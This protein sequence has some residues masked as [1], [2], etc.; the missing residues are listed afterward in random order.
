MKKILN[1]SLLFL[2]TLSFIHA[3]DNTEEEEYEQLTASIPLF[4]K[5]NIPA[6]KERVSSPSTL[7]WEPSH[8]VRGLNILGLVPSGT[9]GV[10]WM[11]ING[12]KEYTTFYEGNWGYR[13]FSFLNLAFSYQ[14]QRMDIKNYTAISYK[15]GRQRF[16]D[17]G[18]LTLHSLMLK[19]YLESP[20]VLR[21][22]HFFITPYVGFAMGPGWIQRGI[23]GTSVRTWEG[24]FGLRFGTVHPASFLSL[25]A[26]CKYVEWG[27]LGHSIAQYLG[28]RLNF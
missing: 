20:Q 1:I 6:P 12:I 15:F 14:N 28:L 23:F 13:I 8:H 7:M 10:G 4:D 17:N 21:V 9:V 24:D 5:E 11:N 18:K 26:G 2:F 25:M 3:E 22:D 16:K 27:S 19:G